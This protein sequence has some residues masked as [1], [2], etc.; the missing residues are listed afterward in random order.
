MQTF[1]F[2]FFLFYMESKRYNKN[3]ISNLFYLNNL[4]ITSSFIF[5]FGTYA[6][7]KNHLTYSHF[8]IFTFNF[9]KIKV[10]SIIFR[11]KINIYLL[12]IKRSFIFAHTQITDC[13]LQ[14]KTFPFKKSKLNYTN[15]QSMCRCF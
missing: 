8:Y 10:I 14:M 13:N 5:I 12:R 9:S 1:I 7:F 6:Y 15:E 2:L 11:K 4:S 3:K